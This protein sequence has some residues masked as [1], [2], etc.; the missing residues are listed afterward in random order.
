[1][2]RVRAGD[3]QTLVDGAALGLQSVILLLETAFS[4][5]NVVYHIVASLAAP[6][7]LPL[8]HAVST[9]SLFQGHG[10]ENITD[11]FP[12]SFG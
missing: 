3:Q 7:T 11:Y 2:S 5:L 4:L 6:F 9:P 12:D 10:S 1:M 8:F